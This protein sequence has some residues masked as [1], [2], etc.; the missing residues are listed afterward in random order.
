MTERG[1]A[2]VLDALRRA[3]GTE[4]VFADEAPLRECSTDASPCLVPP[5]A[6]ERPSSKADVVRLLSVCT[7]H[8]VP[9]TPRAAGTCLSGA[10]IGPGVVLDS[11]RLAAIREFN[12]AEGWV[13]VEPSVALLDL[14]RFLADRGFRFPLEPGS[15]QFCRIGGMIG[16]NASGYGSVKYGQ[17]ADHVIGL[18]VVLATGA[19]LE[20]RDVALDGVEWQA[21]VA[22][23]PALAEVRRI[24]DDHGDAI[25][26]HRRRVR[27]HACGYGLAPLVEAMDRGRFPLARLF[28]GSEGTLGVVTEVALRVQP[29]PAR[30]VTCLLYLDSLEE[31]GPL[32]ADL[33]P[34]RPSAVEGIDG[35]SL[36][37]LGREAHRIPPNARAMILVEFDEGDLDALAAKVVNEVAPRYRV[38]APPEVATDPE[39]QAFLWKARR[40]LFP[41]LLRRPD[42]RRPWGFVE[43]PIV[44]TDRVAEFIGYLMELTRKYGTVAGIYGH[45]GDGNTHYRPVFDPMDPADLERMRSLREEFDDAVLDRFGGAPSGEHGIRRI[46]AD[47]LPRVWGTE[48]YEA[49]R[50]IKDALDPDGILNPGV[51]FSTAEWWETWGGLEAREPL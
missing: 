22:K 32:V 9:V 2:E 12:A 35:D 30:T 10:S 45:L 51:L 41:T 47:F 42:S 44:P 20:A 26:G 39:R 11:S 18:R 49:M 14:N 24:L 17:T 40:S 48:V 38:S 43:D 50:A 31:M 33:L 4:S 7:A 13:R 25:L 34:F 46:R 6:V 29:K 27:K 8:R 19:V 23:A 3:L 21:L 16:H 15:V 28:V 36:D 1:R 5:R 37:V